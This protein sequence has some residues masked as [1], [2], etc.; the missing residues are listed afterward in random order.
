MKCCSWD[1]P[2]LSN[3]TVPMV[4]VMPDRYNELIECEKRMQI[5]EEDADRLARIVARIPAQK[6]IRFAECHVALGQHTVALEARK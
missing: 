5:A 1:K 4:E 3:D 2:K 6:D